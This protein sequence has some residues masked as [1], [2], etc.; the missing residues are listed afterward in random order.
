[1]ASPTKT[2]KHTRTPA[3][4]G[5]SGG[6][7]PTSLPSFDSNTFSAPSDIDLDNLDLNLDPDDVFTSMSVTQVRQYQARVE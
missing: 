3:V 4:L 6:G 5:G 1:M 2:R 7:G